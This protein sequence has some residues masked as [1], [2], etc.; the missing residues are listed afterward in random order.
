[1]KVDPFKSLAREAV[2]TLGLYAASNYF[3]FSKVHHVAAFAAIALS[4]TA[5]RQ[6]ILTKTKTYWETSALNAVVA[7]GDIY[8]VLGSYRLLRQWGD[9][10]TKWKVIGSVGGLAS[11]VYSYKRADGIWNTTPNVDRWGQ[12]PQNHRRSLGAASL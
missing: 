10:S 9:L 5:T 4:R 8:L 1:M 12:R 11:L 6:K 2:Y 3:Q 7:Y